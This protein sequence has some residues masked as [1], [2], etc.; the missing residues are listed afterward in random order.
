MKK[1][2]NVSFDKA[3]PSGKTKRGKRLKY[4]SPKQKQNKNITYDGKKYKIKDGKKNAYRSN[5]MWV[6]SE[7]ALFNCTIPTTATTTRTSTTSKRSCTTFVYGIGIRYLFS[8]LCRP[9]QR[10]Y[11]IYGVVRLFYII[12]F[13]VFYVFFLFVYSPSLSPPPPPAPTATTHTVE[14]H[15]DSR[16]YEQ[17]ILLYIHCIG[18]CRS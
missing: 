6:W 18:T 11:I 2:G 15:P 9:R 17:D 3:K 14:T 13:A 5:T 10:K 4:N 7:F 1:H 16:Q 8:K 12:L